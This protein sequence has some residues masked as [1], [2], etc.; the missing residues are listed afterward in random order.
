MVRLFFSYEIAHISGN[1]N[2]FAGKVGVGTAS[3]E[4]K[5]EISGSVDNGLFQALQITNT[6][7]A[8][9]ET[10]QKVAIN[11]KLSRGGTWRCSRITAGKDGFEDA[12]GADSP[13]S[14]LY[15]IMI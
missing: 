14:L 10:G 3:P 2:Y 12:S 1:S 15:T 9:G 5:V 6:D 13:L 11:F 7:H 8:N 4:T